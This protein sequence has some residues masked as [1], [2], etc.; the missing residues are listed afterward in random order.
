MESNTEILDIW[1]D[2]KSIFIST[3]KESDLKRKAERYLSMVIN[4]VGNNHKLVCYTSTK[5]AAEILTQE[6]AYK[7]RSSL[8]LAGTD[9]NITLT[10]EY[11]SSI[12]PEI[13]VIEEEQEIHVQ[14]Q[15]QRQ[16]FHHI[17]RFAPS[18]YISTMPLISGFTFEEFVRGPSN[19]FAFDAAL[20]VV[21]NL[22]KAVYN[23]L[24]IYGG[25]G[26]GKTHLMHAIGNEIKKNN[27][28]LAVCYLTAEMFLNQ[29]TDTLINKGNTQEFRNKYRNV[30]VLLVDDVQFLQKGQN[31]QEEFFNTFNNLQQSGKQIV[32]TS[33]VAPKNLPHLEERLI[34]RFEGGMV[35]EIELPSYETR[36]AILKKKA[37][38]YGISVPQIA[39]EFIADNIKSHVRAMEGALG[40]LSVYLNNTQNFELTRENLSYIF[41]D[42]IKKEQSIKL[43]SIE[44]IQNTVSKKFGVSINQILSSERTQSIVTPRQLSMYIARK[45]TTKSLQEIA[46][47]FDKSHATIIHGVKTIKERLA[48][49]EDLKRNLE[50][51]V[52]LFGYKMSDVML[53]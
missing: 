21:K 28:H 27:P 29:Y 37:D 7:M 52:T 26:L 32:M 46:V 4:V 45:L 19:S 35:Q 5:L 41:K 43:L 24:F 30:D 47:A 50:E 42:L 25:T 15:P 39:M 8:C 34:S 36:L 51:I 17:N 44:E 40:I 31:V 33:D 22:G 11:D 2:A 12:K 6:Y 49:E 13:K 20:G 38:N 16:E 48:N 3:L 9:E 10:F 53:D 14:S 1:N 23:P 18:N